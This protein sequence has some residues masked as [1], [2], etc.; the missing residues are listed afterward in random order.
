MDS[1]LS[2]NG[3]ARAI[4]AAVELFARWYDEAPE[5]RSPF[6]RNAAHF[7]R[8][9]KELNSGERRWISAAAFGT[10]RLLQRQKSILEALQRE[11]TSES[12]IELW[13]DQSDAAPDSDVAIASNKLPSAESQA[14][15]LR[16]TLSFTDAMATELE[17]LLG[18]EA[19][20]AGEAFNLQAPTTVRINPLRTGIVKAKKALPDATQT[21]YSP[22]ALQLSKRVNIFEQPGFKEGWYE[23]QEEASQ[24]AAL[25]SNAKPG[26]TVIDVGA[27]AGG[28]T[29]AL[30]ALMDNRGTVV[31]LDYSEERLNEMDERAKR[32][33]V[34]N[35]ER[36]RV[37]V[38]DFG[39]WEPRGKALQIL[40]ALNG[41]ADCVF[42]DAPCTGSGAIRRSPDAKW[43]LYDAAK[44]R[45]TQLGLLE[46]SAVLVKPGGAIVYVTCAF[47]KYQNEDVVEA[48]LQSEAGAGFKVDHPLPYLED[49]IHRASIATMGSKHTVWEKADLNDLFTGPYFRSWPHKHGMDA[50]FGARLLRI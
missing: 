20:A 5:D 30:S 46:Q 8:T 3:S 44:M 28:K 38:S 31:A 43:Q 19:A 14:D 6:V 10:V 35:I 25:L 15:Y 9:H 1:E 24:V 37:R 4:R 32:A 47:E 41:R 17:V 21:K 45:E 7:F 23:I 50:F 33:K 48:F 49:A 18:N 16:T 34:T 26:M 22:W 2:L 36:C 27:G 11:V 42:I 39:R 29:L 40:T 12:L 13:R